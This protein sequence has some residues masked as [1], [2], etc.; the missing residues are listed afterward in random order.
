[1][2]NTQLKDRGLKVF[3]E[4]TLLVCEELIKWKLDSS[5][6]PTKLRLHQAVD[7]FGWFYALKVLNKNGGY[8]GR[9]LSGIGYAKNA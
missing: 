4:S 7:N 6:K 2:K 5:F 1:M 9:N 8:Y 3:Q